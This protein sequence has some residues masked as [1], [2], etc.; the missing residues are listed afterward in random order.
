[1]N[2]NYS[3]GRIIFLINKIVFKSVI[4]ILKPKRPSKYL[5]L[6]KKQEFFT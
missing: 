3:V 1:M 5:I 2:V 4:S 6:D